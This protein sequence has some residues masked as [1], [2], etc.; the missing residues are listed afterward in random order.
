MKQVMQILRSLV[1][2]IIAYL[3]IGTVVGIVDGGVQA[4]FPNSMPDPASGQLPASGWL[5]WH[6]GEVGLI[7][8]ASAY[9]AAVMVGRAEL[10]HI[11]IL[12]AWMLLV[13]LAT[14][15]QMAGR[16]P[17]WFA[18]GMVAVPIPAL[19]LGWY[20]RVRRKRAQGSQTDKT[21]HMVARATLWGL[22]LALLL[23]AHDY[24]NDPM[25]RRHFSIRD[26]FWFVELP[27]LLIAGA[28]IGY[29]VGVWRRSKHVHVEEHPSTQPGA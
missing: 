14:Y 8:V 7:T 16:W 28:A 13:G 21:H 9:L 12:G 11:V 26:V 1:V 27:F 19:L 6:V 5:L 3:A 4:L 10:L 29:A 23:A 20:L 25:Y 22:G 24:Q 18:V 2:L 15:A 17:T